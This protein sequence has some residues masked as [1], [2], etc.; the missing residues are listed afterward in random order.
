M[1]RRTIPNSATA[2]TKCDARLRDSVSCHSCAKFQGALHAGGFGDI[3]AS[4]VEGGAV[5]D[6]GAND[7]EADGDVHPAIEIEELHGD[8]ALVVVH[9][10]HQIVL[11]LDGA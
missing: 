3:F 6:G 5:V 8:V 10:H 11:A 2:A 7:G 4:D 9:R 1:L